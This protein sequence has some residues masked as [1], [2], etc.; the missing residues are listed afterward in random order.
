MLTSNTIT[1]R[2]AYL[3]SGGQAGE[4]ILAHAWERHP[5]GP[6]E[7]WPVALRITLGIVLNSSHPMFLI[8]G[9]KNYLF[10][11][12]YY[13]PILG[14][15]SAAALA[16]PFSEVWKEVW[17]ELQPL[18]ERSLRGESVFYE[19]YPITLERHGYPELAYFTFSYSP[20]RDEEGE[21]QG[22]ICT[23]IETTEKV[24]VAARNREAEEQFRFALEASGNIGTWSYELDAEE[25]RVDEHLAM[26]FRKDALQP[27]RMHKPEYFVGLIHPDD[28]P[29]VLS[30]FKEAI[31]TGARY[32]IE[33]RLVPSQDLTVWIA[34]RG[35][36]VRDASS[37]KRR[38][39]GVAIDIS[40]LKAALLERDEAAQRAEVESA[41]AS[42]NGRVLEALLESAPV[43]IVFVDRAGKLVLANSTNQDIWGQ[44]PTP[45]TVGDYGEWKGWW[46]PGM[47][48][49]GELIR[50]D[51][52]PLSRVLSGEPM[53]EC[54]AEIEP[55]G[56]PGVR[57]IIAVR[58]AGVRRH[59]VELVGAV[60]AN[61]DITAQV[62]AEAA[63]K[64]SEERFRSITDVIPQIVWSA[65]ATGKN[66]YINNRW[67]EFTGVPNT[68]TLGDDWHTFIHDEDLPLLLA[69]W[70]KSLEYG[71]RLEI[72]HRLQHCSGA[73]RWVLNRAIPTLDEAGQV[74]RWMGTLTDVHD[75]KLAEQGLKLSARK[76]DEFL[77]M[78]A[79]ELR[80]PLAPI[81]AASEVLNIA[82]DDS[83]RVRRTAG[84]IARQVRHM[85]E[86]VDDLL[87]VS[88][89][90][91][92]LVQ[93][94]LEN[95]DV[96]DII[97]SAVEQVKPLLESR[98]QH[99]ELMLGPASA[100]VRG[101]R[102]RLVQVIANLLNNAAKYTGQGG[103]VSVKV[104]VTE[105]TVSIAVTD[106]GIGISS[107]LLP[108]V[109][110]LFTQAERTPDRSQG[111]LGLGL[112]LVRSL[113]ALH[114]G[115]VSVESPGV[116]RGSTF[117]VFLPSLR[118]EEDSLAD[119]AGKRVETA[120]EVPHTTLNVMVVDD[121]LD[122]ARSLAEVL[123]AFNHVVA[124]SEHP[125]DAL[126]QVQAN[127]P[128][129]FILDIGLPEMDG[130]EL[131][132]H[133]ITHQGDRKTRYIALTGYGQ[134]HDRIL[135]KS[136]GFH[137]HFVK[138]VDLHE[139][140]ATIQSPLSSSSS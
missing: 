136:A 51:E 67:A 53:A 65:D 88:R 114:N 100:L 32:D 45:E 105:H 25:F 28:R 124:V 128:D 116:G 12:D 101:D 104:E 58:A 17:D 112:A 60:A 139:L 52:W 4:A 15:K 131:V 5:L 40:R 122:A 81:V 82:P 27:E 118:H 111:G 56:Q 39:A 127:W 33:Y 78:L 49:Q 119:Q 97:A 95:V 64:E 87:D 62:A 26:L 61:M 11:N 133:L 126:E 1:G 96:S 70:Q 134:S 71:S 110:E 85:T 140:L 23:V 13:A 98:S 125:L 24:E 89:V 93:L 66:D 7:T 84:V 19:D 43:G 18:V 80:N 138:P 6:P 20:V 137:H 48:R 99:L 59:G 63:F 91:R 117:R 94:D 75:R 38:F 2:F 22:L 108:Q 76:K 69:T 16:Q 121:N 31:D 54:V 37:G 90:T 57:R 129:V 115:T 55:F 21:T 36:V 132:R 113:T 29:R 3:R 109:F 107:Q 47:D 123:E 35:Q 73:Y 44:H 9:D 135:S 10:Y 86:L 106:T 42:E 83:E 77:A 103:H 41:R 68:G 30:T 14:G 46:G 34:A 130:Y 120:A 79:H 74:K 92:G 50:S 102:T 8:W 72:E